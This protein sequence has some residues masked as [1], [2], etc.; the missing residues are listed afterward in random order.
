MS[1]W[2]QKWYRGRLVYV[3]CVIVVLTILAHYAGVPWP[4]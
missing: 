2:R 1:H 3:L 4:P